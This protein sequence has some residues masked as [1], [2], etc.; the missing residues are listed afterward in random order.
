MRSTYA[1]SNGSAASPTPQSGRAASEPR[2]CARPRSFG[3]SDSSSASGRKRQAIARPSV[4]IISGRPPSS[5][6]PPPPPRSPLALLPLPPLPMQA[7][8]LP[9]GTDGAAAGASSTGCAS[10]ILAGREASL[11]PPRRAGPRAGARRREMPVARCHRRWPRLGNVSVVLV[12][13]RP[14]AL[15]APPPAPVAVAEQSRAGEAEVDGREARSHG[16]DRAAHRGRP[17]RIQRRASPSAARPRAA[18]HRQRLQRR[19]VRAAHG[20]LQLSVECGGEAASSDGRGLRARRRAP[21]ASRS[22]ATARPQPRST[23]ERAVLAYSRKPLRSSYELAPPPRARRR[24][25]ER[26]GPTARG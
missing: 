8:S 5:K 1:C 17:A 24:A 4:S 2:D 18:S 16:V 11:M 15:A 14:P 21:E 9:T 13:A 25:V 6:P 12:S 10:S 7:P 26:H 3:R 22:A 23:T 19:R 20:A